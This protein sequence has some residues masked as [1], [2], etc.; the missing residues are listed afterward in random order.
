MD[1]WYCMP[2]GE[3]YRKEEIEKENQL[4]TACI[5]N[6]REKRERKKIWI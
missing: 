6:K 3:Q 4:Q 2:A 1:I 5:R